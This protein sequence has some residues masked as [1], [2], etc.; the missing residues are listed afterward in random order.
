M[1]KNLVSLFLVLCLA[2]S[3]SVPAYAANNDTDTTNDEDTQSLKASARLITTAEDGTVTTTPL[4]VEVTTTE[5][6]VPHLLYVNGADTKYYATTATTKPSHEPG[7]KVK[8]NVTAQMTIHWI[9]HF[10]I[11]N[12]FAGLDGSWQPMTGTSPTLFGREVS[13]KG[14][15]ASGDEGPVIRRY[16]S[17]DKFEIPASS[18]TSKWLLFRARSAVYV[19]S[20]DNLLELEFTT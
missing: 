17:G 18:Y 6:S 10:G 15:G 1:K 14:Q 3:L 7:I 4:N 9:D 20:K 19:N 11:R 5:I 2:I 8:Y 13:M 12:E 16:P